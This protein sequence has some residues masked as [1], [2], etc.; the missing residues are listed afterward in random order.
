M[1]SSKKIAFL[2]ND[3]LFGLIVGFCSDGNY[4]IAGSE[5]MDV[6]IIQVRTFGERYKTSFRHLAH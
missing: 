6:K 1:L 4:V 5:F 2:I 3:K